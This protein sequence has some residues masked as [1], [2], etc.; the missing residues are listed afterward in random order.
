MITKDMTVLDIIAECPETEDV[1]RS[2][3]EIAGQCT[4]CHNLFETMEEFTDIY[5]I[6]LNS[7]IQMLENSL[8]KS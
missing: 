1:F 3:D 4:M 7:L 5:N 8:K 2:F 6:D